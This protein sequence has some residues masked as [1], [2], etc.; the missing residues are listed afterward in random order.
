M[1]QQ[2]S[3][4]LPPARRKND[5]STCV[6]PDGRALNDLHNQVLDALEM[7]GPMTDEQ[8]EQLPQF[9]SFGPSTIRKRRSELYQ[10]G[11]LRRHG[12]RQN[13]RGRYM[14]VWGVYV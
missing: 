12:E 14:V 2:I 6:A 1:N 9:K 8:L 5:P 7:Y 10:M 11:R 3:L 13:S 4:I